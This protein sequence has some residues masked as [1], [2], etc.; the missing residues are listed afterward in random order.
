MAD[1]DT[2]SGTSGTA[3]GGTAD[4]HALARRFF[5]EVWNQGDES[6]I[7]RYIAADAA[8]NDETFGIGREGFRTQWRQWQA[9]FE[10]LHFA[11]EEI[12]AEGDRVVTRW[13]LT[14]RHVGPFL[15][16]PATGR[17]VRAAGMSLD[18]VRDGVLVAGVDAWDELGLRR[19]LGD[20]PAG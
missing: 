7:D 9:A 16:I 12:V 20:V 4:L 6:A 3:T 15:G 11:V 14:G 10:G 18:T 5:E 1:G 2:T 8:G 13:T 19:Q 17:D